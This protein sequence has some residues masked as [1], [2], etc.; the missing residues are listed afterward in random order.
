MK[1]IVKYLSATLLALVVLT[2]CNE[3][4]PQGT[5]G[6]ILTKNGFEPEVYPPSRVWVDNGITA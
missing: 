4:V 5:V 2:G 1:N 6:K 3:T